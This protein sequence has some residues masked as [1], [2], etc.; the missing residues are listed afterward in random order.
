MR[1]STKCASW[2][3]LSLLLLAG[4][5]S[6]GSSATDPNQI[7]FN[8]F[9]S[10]VG[11]APNVESLS[12][13][14]AHSGKYSVKV[15]PGTLFGVGYSTQLNKVFDHK[16]HKIRISG[17]GYMTDSRSGAR[18]G[19]QVFDLAQNK[20]VYGDGVDF[21]DAV[22]TPGKWV[23]IEKVITLPPAVT[24]EQQMRVF[25]YGAGAGSPAYIDDMRISDV[26]E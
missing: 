3:A 17:W 11:W 13:E 14:Q 16:P 6:S 26:P 5:K 19:F 8:D 23:E 15:G 7:S 24:G 18:L 10:M 20:E 4:C 1:F 2:A 9:E 25:L 22:K 12:R 21:N